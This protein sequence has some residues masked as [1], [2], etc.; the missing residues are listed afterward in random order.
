MSQVREITDYLRQTVELGGSDLHLSAWA[1]PAARVGG[2]LNPLEDFLLDPDTVRRLILDT[3]SEAQRAALEQN[4]ELDYALQLEGVGRFRGNVHIARG[5]HEA[6]FRHIPQH[7][8]DLGELGHHA[9]VHDLCQ[10]RRGLV[11]VTGITGSGKS[12]TLASMVKR[13]SENRSGVI[14][15]IEDPIE[16]T[17]THASCLIKQREVGSD[18]KGFAIAL[19]QALRQD[20][21]V[22]VVSELRD[23]ETIRIALTAAETGHL[24]LATLHTVDAPQSIDRLVDVFPPDQQPQIVTQLSGVLEAI[25]SQ[26][27]IQRADGRGRVLASEVLRANHGIRACIRERKLEQIVG[28]ME[29]G[30]KDGSRTIDQTIQMLLD[31]GFITREEALFNCREKRNFMEQPQQQAEAKKPKSIWT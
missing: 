17:F 11:L 12:T 15:T 19:R 23:L 20:P 30:F 26:R 16:F 27:L 6:A 1:P 13:I 8:P 9:V 14:V 21:D 7:I 28:L 2:N 25:V 5:C 31:S 24:V 4:W 18:T 22:V 10:L 3:L 29:I